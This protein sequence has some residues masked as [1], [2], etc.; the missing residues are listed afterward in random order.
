VTVSTPVTKVA[1][2]AVKSASVRMVFRRFWPY[3][4]ADRRFLWFAILLLVASGA[5]ETAAV[6]SFGSIVNDA[7]ARASLAGFWRPAA[8]WV[9]LAAV[10]GFASFGTGWLTALLTERFLLRLRDAV[11]S[12]LQLLSPDFFAGHDTGD[13]VAR[14]TSDIDMIEQFAASGVITTVGAVI[15]VVF[16]AGAA[17]FISWPLAVAA[18]VLAPLFWLA[19][20]SFSKKIKVVSRDE[21][22]Y[23]GMITATVQESL[24]NLTLVQ[25]YNQQRADRSRLHGHGI[26]WM[27]VRI[28]EAKL[29]G[30]YTPL[31]DIAE[32][33][34]LLAV[35]GAGVW[36]IGHGRLTP[37]AVLAFTAYLG[38]LY[39]PLRELGYLSITAN[40]AIASS[41]RIVELLDAR[42]SVA[43]APYARVL[44]G[45][46]G[47]LELDHV[48][49]TYPGTDTPALRDLSFSVRRGQFVLIT[50]A[51][52]AG[53][54]TITK[55]LLRFA[56]PS[57]GSIRLDG[58]DMRALTV[59]SLREQVTLVL[60]R[61]QVFQGTVRENIAFGRPD[62]TPAEIVAAAVAADADEFISELPDGYDT[63][64]DG[65]GERL[66]GG[67][68]HR[69]A[70]ARAILRDTPVLVLDEPTA[71]LD[72]LA[73]RR[74]IEPLR[75]LAHGR[76][77]IVISHDLS[78][79][80][81]ADQVLVLERGQLVEQGKHED[82]VRAGGP[83][84]RLYAQHVPEIGA[85]ERALPALESDRGLL[86]AAP[87]RAL[88]AAEPDRALPP[89]AP[90]RALPPLESLE[91]PTLE[92]AALGQA[93]SRREPAPA[94]S[95][96]SR[97][98]TES[99]G[100]WRIQGILTGLEPDPQ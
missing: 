10:G 66:S 76:T 1:G 5:A 89:A 67:Q 53:K 34:C 38:Y 79:A 24:T 41:D 60:Q 29:S 94:R 15:T 28:Q 33:T 31:V 99:G 49:Y 35:I 74:V 3:L 26:S 39:A 21:R 68:L 84:A 4:R 19:A 71:G 80:P 96:S 23:N 16:Y 75:R 82:L 25:A 98:R 61:T 91:A 88:P 46:T 77:T 93:S 73:A 90:E 45:A 18:F 95:E 83:Y 27:R 70:I 85:G 14:L 58:F 47:D 97:P 30:A 52:G 64:L 37:G 11:Y 17:T 42:P 57:T 69:L 44:A 59:E 55:L 40:A 100:R 63:V 50:G 6:W 54:S 86:P 36:E 87:A 72:G 7:L 22:D 12:Q 81:L 2:I 78:V 48:S 51:S 65:A 56:D 43:D 13:L 8:T 20:R 92:I 62:A 32:I 9:A